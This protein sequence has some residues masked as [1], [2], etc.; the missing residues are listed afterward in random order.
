MGHNSDREQLVVKIIRAKN[1][2]AKDTNGYSDPFVKVYLLPGREW[3]L[4]RRS[5]TLMNNW[6]LPSSSQE[7][8]RRTKYISKNLNPLWDHTV[9]YGNMHREELQYKMLEFT[10]WDYDRFKANDFLGQVTINLKG[11]STQCTAL[12]HCIDFL[13]SL[14][15]NVIDD[16]P[17]WYRLQALRSREEV[18][19][20]GSSPGLYKMTSVDST[21]SSTVTLNRNTINM[22][23]RVNQRPWLN[24][25]DFVVFLR[26]CALL[27]P[28]LSFYYFSIA[29]FSLIYCWLIGLRY[30]EQSM[31]CLIVGT[32][33]DTQNEHCLRCARSLTIVEKFNVDSIWFATRRQT[34]PSSEGEYLWAADKR[35]EYFSEQTFAMAF[36]ETFKK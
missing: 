34:N 24:G 36:V 1:L 33:Q 23:S 29:P 14:D 7:N 10:V 19:N 4:L 8:K 35:R 11:Q 27:S 32:Q 30:D 20:R 12:S 2:L 17:H 9:I 6:N 22:Q 3:V 18:S 5:A 16:K 26:F 25:S 28:S 21:A 13:S 15:A 31:A